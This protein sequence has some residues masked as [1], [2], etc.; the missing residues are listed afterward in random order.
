MEGGAP[1]VEGADVTPAHG[2]IPAAAAVEPDGQG[3]PPAV[4]AVGIKTLPLSGTVD[5]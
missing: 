5:T 4:S 2:G 3:A 1:V